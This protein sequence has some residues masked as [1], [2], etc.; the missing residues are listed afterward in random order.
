MHK[1]ARNFWTLLCSILLKLKLSENTVL[2]S[3]LF[4]L[5]ENSSH[6]F[7]STLRSPEYFLLLLDSASSPQWRLL[8]LN[9]NWW[10]RT[11]LRRNHLFINEWQISLLSDKAVTPHLT[12][13]VS[14]LFV[15]SIIKPLMVEPMDDWLAFRDGVHLTEMYLLMVTAVFPRWSGW[16]MICFHRR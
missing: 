14:D 2:C 4:I 7:L 5:P 10:R 15:R 13:A 9:L 11:S 16:G 12:N 8:H 1:V 6:S 3:T